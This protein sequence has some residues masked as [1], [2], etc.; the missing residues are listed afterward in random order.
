MKTQNNNSHPDNTQLESL[1]RKGA[2]SQ[3]LEPS[4][5]L[6]ARVLSQITAA[7]NDSSP[8]RSARFP[9][10][11]RFRYALAASIALIIIASR[12]LTPPQSTPAPITNP[13]ALITSLGPAPSVPLATDLKTAAY[14]TIFQP[15]ATERDA[16]L[17]DATLYTQSISRSLQSFARVLTVSNSGASTGF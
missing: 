10:R 15:Y 17:H 13:L 2:P 1:L 4:H 3:L 16:L 11:I 9:Q 5:P 6:R 7:P 14:N 12:V 8:R